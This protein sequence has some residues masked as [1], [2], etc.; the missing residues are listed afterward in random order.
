[1]PSVWGAVLV[2][3]LA[4][5]APVAAQSPSG[6]PPRDARHCPDDHPVKGYATKRGQGV[7]FAPGSPQYDQ[8]NPERCFVNEAEAQDGGYRPARNERPTRERH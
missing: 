8:A 1:M 7:F 2:W 6:V 5:G 3:L 4:V